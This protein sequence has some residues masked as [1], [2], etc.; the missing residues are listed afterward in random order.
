MSLTSPQ[1]SFALVKITSPQ[2]RSIISKA[3]FATLVFT[4]LGFRCGEMKSIVGEMDTREESLV[5]QAVVCTPGH[6][7]KDLNPCKNHSGFPIQHRCCYKYR[8]FPRIGPIDFHYVATRPRATCT[9]LP[10]VF[11]YSSKIAN[12]HK[13]I[14]TSQNHALTN[15]LYDAWCSQECHYQEYQNK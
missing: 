10:N 6:S 15:E 7:A 2:P 12:K 9:H 8:R 11:L 1:S 14:C 4:R 13:T 3:N 5:E